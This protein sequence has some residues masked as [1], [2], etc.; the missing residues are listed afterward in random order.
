M[1]VL[2]CSS[3]SDADLLKSY[4]TTY[5]GHSAQAYYEGKQ[6]LSTFAGSDCSFGVGDWNSGWQQAVKTPLASTGNEIFFIPS[7]FTDPSTFSGVSVMDGELNWNSAWTSGDSLNTWH[8][9]DRYLAGL[10]SKAYMAAVAPGFFT[11]TFAVRRFLGPKSACTDLMALLPSRQT[12]V[13]SPLPA[14][15]ASLAPGTDV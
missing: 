3:F 7:V 4:V 2:P 14:Q 9:D 6:L 12:T 8:S 13:V 15:P 10:G 1:T 5:A 11:R